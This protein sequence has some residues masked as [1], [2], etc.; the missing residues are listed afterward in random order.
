MWRH[1]GAHDISQSA[2]R[3]QRSRPALNDSSVSQRGSLI[4]PYDERAPLSLVAT[5]SSLSDPGKDKPSGQTLEASGPARRQIP[6][7]A[8]EKRK[9]L[10]YSIEYSFLGVSASGGARAALLNPSRC[11]VRLEDGQ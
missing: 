10:F 11:V 5:A 4:R 1:A 6:A 9:G 7:V 3:S 2:R 8:I